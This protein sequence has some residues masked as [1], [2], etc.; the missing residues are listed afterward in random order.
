MHLRDRNQLDISDEMLSKD[1]N[2]IVQPQP[3]VLDVE[4][5]LSLNHSDIKGNCD[6]VVDAAGGATYLDPPI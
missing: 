2:I 3:L 4:M 6:A 5:Q 1:G